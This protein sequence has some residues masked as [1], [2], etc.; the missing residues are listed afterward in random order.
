MSKSALGKIYPIKIGGIDGTIHTPYLPNWSEEEKRPLQKPLIP[1]DVAVKWRQGGDIFW[2][3]PCGYPEGDSLLHKVLFVFEVENL[4]DDGKKIKKSFI[5]WFHLLLD[6]IEIL[7]NQNARTDQSLNIYGDSFNVFYWQHNGKAKGISSTES[8]VISL[9]NWQK[10]IDSEIFLRA[11]KLAS[12]GLQPKLS[13]KLYLEANKA[14][15]QKDYRKTVIECGTAIEYAL[16]EKIISVFKTC[17]KSSCEILRLL[18]QR[19][20]KTLG[21]RFNLADERL[22]IDL[23]QNEYDYRKVLIGPRNDAIHDGQFIS[24]RDARR[25]IEYTQKLLS[26]ILPEIL[27]EQESFSMRNSCVS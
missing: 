9:D 11:C 17:G 12:S 22:N 26:E 18:D 7:S 14:Y 21:G 27:E 6:Y 2:G 23:L 5:S 10:C 8:V 24:E 16:T 3:K 20:N 13:Y 15:L 19:G 25:A 4:E 1:P